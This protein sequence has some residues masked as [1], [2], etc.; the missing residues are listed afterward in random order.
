[1]RSIKDI[2]KKIVY[3]EKASSETYTKYLRDKGVLVGKGT[4]FYA[5]RTTEIDVTRPYMVQI[6]EYV[7][8][9][10]G[11]T[12]MT[13]GYDWSVIRGVTYDMYG[14]AGPVKI[15][16]NVFVGTNSTI[17]KGVTIGNNVVIGAGTLVNRD[18]PDNCVAAGNPVRIICDLESY[19]VKRE[20]ERLA[21]A[22]SVVREYY[23]RYGKL[24]PVEELYEFFWLFEPRVQG[25]EPGYSG[26]NFN[27]RMRRWEF[28]PQLVSRYFET[29]AVY[30]SYGEF[31]EDCGL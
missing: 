13:H 12:I 17:L 21:D 19:R 30:G 14:S 7:H 25:K 11:V 3:R 20:K 9:T 29:E 4:Y 22:K 23:A 16:S 1:M 24:P 6:G 5:P 15:G 27:E 28:Y 26:K 10:H 31:I 2:F 8:I 18:I